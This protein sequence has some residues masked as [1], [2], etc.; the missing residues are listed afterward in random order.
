M[1]PTPHEVEA[2]T[3]R[4]E[5]LVEQIRPILA[6]QDAIVGAAMGELSAILIV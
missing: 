6:G 5:V 2:L 1:T 4:A 3:Q